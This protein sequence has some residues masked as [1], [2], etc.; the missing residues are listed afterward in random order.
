MFELIQRPELIEPL[1]NEVE[2]VINEHGW[3]KP[4]LTHMRRLDSFLKEVTRLR[5][6][7]IGTIQ[8]PPRFFTVL[9][10]IVG[11]PHK[12]MR[13][14]SLSDGTK[15]PKGA[16]IVIATKAR[17]HDESLYED[18]SEFKGFRFSDI[19]EGELHRGKNVFAA[20]NMDHL[21]FGSNKHI[22]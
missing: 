12:A 17:H 10:E 19:P 11:A 8:I 2:T 5:H 13:E 15:I 1:R 6:G 21:G 9:I 18:P 16:Y 22:W 14:C 7:D 4:A 3:N 20:A